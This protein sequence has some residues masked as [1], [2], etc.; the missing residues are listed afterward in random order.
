[1]LYPPATFAKPNWCKNDRMGPLSDCE[2]LGSSQ[3]KTDQIGWARIV[4][5]L[6]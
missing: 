1:M 4:R 2:L 3:A 6:S 5:N